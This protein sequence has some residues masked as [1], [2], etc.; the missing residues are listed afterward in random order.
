M[1]I[2][3]SGRNGEGSKP[4]CLV[5]SSVGPDLMCGCL[6]GESCERMHE[7]GQWD[8][9]ILPPQKL[10]GDIKC[11]ELTQQIVEVFQ[12]WKTTINLPCMNPDLA[13]KAQL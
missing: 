8:E 1:S 7:G 3:W 11:T 6:A 13:Y 4:V 5:S 2:G 10:H 9:E 12:Q